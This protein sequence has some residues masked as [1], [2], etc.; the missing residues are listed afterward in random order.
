MCIRI[1][2]IQLLLFPRIC[3]IMAILHLLKPI[4]WCGSLCSCGSSAWCVCCASLAWCASLMKWRKWATL[5]ESFFKLLRVFFSSEGY[6]N[7]TV[8]YTHYMSAAWWPNIGLLSSLGVER[9]PGGSSSSVP[10]PVL[11]HDDFPAVPLERL[12]AVFRSDARRVS[13]RLLDPTR[14]SHG[15]LIC[16]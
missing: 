10:N 6:L 2:A 11:V 8:A 9:Q 15:N 7:C 13:I 14:K 5:H 3:N 4:E 16:S 1:F 12:R